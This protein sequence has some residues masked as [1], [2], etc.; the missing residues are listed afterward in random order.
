MGYYYMDG[1]PAGRAG[2]GPGRPQLSMRYRTHAQCAHSI[3]EGNT[4]MRDNPGP[5]GPKPPPNPG[6]PPGQGPGK[7]GPIPPAPPKGS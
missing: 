1:Q 4:N 2:R 5:S 3:R 6:K 7:Q